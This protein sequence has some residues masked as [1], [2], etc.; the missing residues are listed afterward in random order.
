MDVHRPT[1][2]S[3]LAVIAFV[4]AALAGAL[5]VFAVA[6]LA[7]RAEAVDTD[8]T[9]LGAVPALVLVCAALGCLFPERGWRHGLVAGVTAALL[10][11]VLLAVGGMHAETLV[12]GVPL[13]VALAAATTFASAVG[14]RVRRALEAHRSTR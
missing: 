6:W 12:L 5:F 9:M 2:H 1:T 4:P 7:L 8:A 14:S 13:I 11:S 3:E 10:G